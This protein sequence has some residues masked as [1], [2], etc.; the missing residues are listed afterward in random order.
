[1]DCMALQ[2]SGKACR[3][4]V[5]SFNATASA[6]YHLWQRGITG[7]RRSESDVQADADT[8]AVAASPADSDV[9]ST[10]AAA[11]LAFDGLPLQLTNCTDASPLASSQL[12]RLTTERGTPKEE[13][14]K[15]EGLCLWHRF[16]IAALPGLCLSLGQTRTPRNPFQ[17]QAQLAACA[18]KGKE[19][20]MRARLHFSGKLGIGISTG[21]ASTSL[22]GTFGT[23]KTTHRVSDFRRGLPEHN[24]T[25]GFWPACVGSPLLLPK[26]CWSHVST[27]MSMHM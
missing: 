15:C 17:I 6:F 12:W 13:S 18:V 26:P 8:T 22:S 21:G 24:L 7:R 16:A 10:R 14:G 27:H 9:G 5:I 23:I 20:A 19:A 25:C 1:M 2:V 3:P 4:Q 11:G